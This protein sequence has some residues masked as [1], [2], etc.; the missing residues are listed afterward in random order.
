[1]KKISIIL[2]LF[3]TILLFSQ[4]LSKSHQK[5]LE[6]SLQ[7]L[8]QIKI[9]TATKNPEK[10]LD[11]PAS[12][13][14]IT[15]EE[16]ELLGYRS[17]TEILDNIAGFYMIDDYH[18]LGHKNFG[19]RGFFSPGAFGNVVVL[20]NGVPQLSDEYMDYPD[21]KITVPVEAIDRIEIVRGPMSVMYGN[22]AFFGAINIITNENHA[23][24]QIS[25]GLGNYDEKNGSF[26][27]STR[28]KDM[29][30]RINGGFS[31]NSGLDMKYTDLTSN[32]DLIEYAG[33]DKDASIDGM[34]E[35][36]RKY[37]DFSFQKKY[38][39]GNYSYNESLTEILDGMPS[40]GDGSEITHLSTNINLGIDKKFNENFNFRA[41][42]GYYYR[43]HHLD[44]EI[45]Y[46]NS[47]GLDSQKSSAFDIDITSKYTNEKIEVL[48]GLYTRNVIELMQVADFP[49][50]SIKRGDG[51]IMI[52]RN[53]YISTQA[54]YSQITLNHN[55]IIHVIGGIRFEHLSPYKILYSRGV[56]TL[57]TTVNL[58]VSERVYIN[59]NIQPVDD[60]IALTPSI[61]VLYDINEKNVL[62]LMYGTAIKQPTFMDNL[63]QTILSQPF[64]K[65]QRI[66]TFE[67]NYLS[68]ITKN[69]NT[70]ISIFYNHLY[71]LITQTNEFSPETGW[72][73]LGT[74]E[75][76]LATTGVEANFRYQIFNKTCSN[77][78]IIYQ[79]T[80]N[81]EPGF[82][83]YDIG[84]SPKILG[85]ISFHYYFVK[86]V[87]IAI[88]GKYI[89]KMKTAWQT[90]TTPEE[91]QRI[92][93]AIPAY[94]TFD[95]NLRFNNLFNSSF[96]LNLGIKNILDE[97]IRYP[98][99][100]SN[101]WVDKGYLGFGRRFFINIYYN[102]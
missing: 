93:D 30:L 83:K 56:S 38:I 86:N 3:F 97:E 58:P 90:N 66:S 71:N 75:G 62:K 89:G 85:N 54:I 100:K 67:L 102:F 2:S 32:T 40:F 41:M 45:F 36:G 16:I 23:K 7:D 51:E 94:S 77:F 88:T 57:D 78:S 64:L 39:F 13:V 31:S 6:M 59:K 27:I 37:F 29:K 72:K 8:M 5:L 15:A 65:P 14:L 70:N 33:L 20:I 84:Y 73:F 87:S 18:Y 19:V 53:D 28:H 17:Y 1:M 92:S 79:E 43:N 55:N 68:T 74:N 26:T 96:A 95:T 52:P 63:R 44:Y 91:G 61:A 21:T 47:F 49:Q 60:G 9:V 99:T 22:G 24:N 80:K 98:T 101:S 50:I 25:V 81:I 42:F 4:D 12:V 69:I 10:I 34:L 76:E 48:I 11:I 46:S 35:S 82:E